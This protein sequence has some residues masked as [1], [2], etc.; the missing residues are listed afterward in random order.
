MT[1]D[2]I[3]VIAKPVLARDVNG[4]TMFARLLEKNSVNVCTSG[5]IAEEGPMA[6]KVNGKLVQFQASVEKSAEK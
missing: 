6:Y 3:T 5:K 1:Y 4:S 2:Y